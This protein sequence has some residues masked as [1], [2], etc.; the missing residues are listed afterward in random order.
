MRCRV[1]SCAGVLALVLGVGGCCWF[2]KRSCYPACKIPLPKIVVLEK[3]C[4]LPQ[5][6]LPGFKQATSCPAGHVCFDRQNAA[7]L[8]VRLA[9][10]KDFAKEA[11]SR[12]T[13]KLPTSRPTTL[14]ASKSTTSQPTR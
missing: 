6:K 12:C 11:R 3:K 14:P 13:K 1:A 7:Q 4:E 10:L 8:Y 2:A 9:R 5:L